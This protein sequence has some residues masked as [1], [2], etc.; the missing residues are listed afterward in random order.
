MIEQVAASAA[1]KHLV[2]LRSDIGKRKK[3]GARAG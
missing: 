1:R 3:A 2:A